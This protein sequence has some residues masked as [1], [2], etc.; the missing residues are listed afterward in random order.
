MEMGRPKGTSTEPMVEPMVLPERKD[1]TEHKEEAS[2]SQAPVAE[3]TI[4]L[5]SRYPQYTLTISAEHRRHVEDEKT[6]ELMIFKSPGLVAKFIKNRCS[7]PAKYEDSLKSKPYYG[8]DW[9]T[10][11]D[12]NKMIDAEP[13]RAAS[14]MNE[15]DRRRKNVRLD[16]VQ[17]TITKW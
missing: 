16:P 14:F 17:K 7:I 10:M 15:L 5:I 9:M 4:D 12:F 13:I 8:I 6:G 3:P 1:V 2:P 11:T